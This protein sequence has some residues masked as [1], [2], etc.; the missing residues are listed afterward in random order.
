[1]QF[2]YRDPYS[3]SFAGN[4]K[5]QYEQTILY[6]FGFTN[7]ISDFWAIDIK[8]YAKDISKQVGTTMVFGKEGVPVELCDNKGYARARGL[9]FEL[10]KRYSDFISGKATYT[11]QWTSGYSSSAFDDYI[12]SQTN[13]PYPIRERPL[14]WDIR[15][16]VIFQGTLAVPPNGQPTPFGLKLPGDW[17]LTALYRFST[18]QPYT[19]GEASINPVEAQ[20]RENTAI[21]PSFLWTDLKFEKGFTFGG[22]RLAFTVDIFNLLDEKNIQM[23]YGFNTWT[24]KPFRYGDI[25]SP[26][27]NFYDYYTML[28]LM[29][30]RQFSSGRTTKLGIRIDF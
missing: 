16:Q 5:L 10:N 22:I 26:Y 27:L 21:G 29:D 2:F 3:G 14:G 4:P 9:E 30:P 6:E 18:G 24:G 15:H 20:K 12:R 17:N 28:S 11:I 8:S 7:Q 25:E 19:P 13:F 23:S 1:L